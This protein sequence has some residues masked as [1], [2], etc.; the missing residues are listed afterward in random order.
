M[1]RFVPVLATAFVSVAAAAA[2]SGPGY[3]RMIGPSALRFRESPATQKS[4]LPPLS[5]DESTANFPVSISAPAAQA[6]LSA[7]SPATSAAEM[8]GPNTNE[9]FVTPQMLV[10]FFRNRNNGTGRGTTAVVP[11]G[12]VPPDGGAKASSSATYN[13]P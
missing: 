8:V 6:A 13:S 12:F 9:V 5:K 7:T 3:L 11:F 10:E 1:K 4:F 2:A